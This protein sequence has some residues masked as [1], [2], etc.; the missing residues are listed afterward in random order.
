LE[1]DP[2]AR[3]AALEAELA[4]V[5]AEAATERERFERR[6][7]L[8][9][10][11]LPERRD[12]RTVTQNIAAQQEIEALRGALRERDRVVKELTEQVRGLEDQLEDH[13]RRFDELRRRV[14]QREAELEDARRQSQ[15][16]A[17]RVDRAAPAPPPRPQ[18]SLRPPPPPP[19]PE[20]AD[21]VALIIGLVVGALLAA[22][23]AVGLWWTGNLPPPP[24]FGA[25]PSAG[26]RPAQVAAAPPGPQ[27]HVG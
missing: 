25:G 21:A 27:Q 10:S 6:L 12:P 3:I 23:A 22:P 8:A 14:E 4:G 1:R 20:K 7:K 2:T 9:Q 16:A 18:P 19:P 24:T 11:A 17:R 26:E 13:Y 15:L 5:R